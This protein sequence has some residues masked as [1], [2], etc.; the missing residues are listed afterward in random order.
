MEKHQ[1]WKR[2]F[3]KK[4][5]NFGFLVLSTDKMLKA[6]SN[7]KITLCDGTFKSTPKLFQ[8]LLS[9]FGVKAGRKLPLIFALMKRKTTGDY[10]ILFK[11][12]K[13]K[14]SSSPHNPTGNP[15]FYCPVSKGVSDRLL[16][17]NFGKRSIGG[18]ILISR[19]QF[20][21]KSNFSV[22]RNRTTP[23]LI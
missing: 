20:T 10:R 6:S 13:E 12:L 22:L 9:M 8:Q 17:V 4:D 3:L 11:I 1:K 23:T 7:S 16:K 5:K 15:K 19:N 18:V 21:E 14:I 2:F